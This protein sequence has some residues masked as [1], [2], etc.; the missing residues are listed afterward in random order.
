MRSVRSL[1]LIAEN[2]PGFINITDYEITSIYL[3][4]GLHLLF[5]CWLHLKPAPPHLSSGLANGQYQSP[6]QVVS[7]IH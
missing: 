7:C 4:F 2:Q 3:F 6:K 1:D 5:I